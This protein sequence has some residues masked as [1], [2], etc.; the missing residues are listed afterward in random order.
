MSLSTWYHVSFDDEKIYRETNPPNGEGC[1]D[2]LYWQNL[3]RV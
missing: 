3:T 2:E 1:K